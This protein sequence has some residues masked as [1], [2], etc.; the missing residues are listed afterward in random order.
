MQIKQKQLSVSGIK[1]FIEENGQE[2]A[3]AYLYIL[4]NDLHQQPFGFLED[5]SVDG[6]FQSRGIGS[7]LI[8]NI[9]TVAKENGCYKVVG[10]SRYERDDVHQFYLKLGFKDYG[11]EFRF[12]F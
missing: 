3:R 5:V 2:I 6:N 12:D 9:L 10:T 1:F 4:N 7:E 8:K 11:K